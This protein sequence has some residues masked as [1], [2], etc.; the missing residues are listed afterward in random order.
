MTIDLSAVKEEIEQA[1]W[2]EFEP[3][4]FERRVYLGTVHALTPSGKF[5]TSF[6][7][8]NVSEAEAQGDM[9]FYERLDAE[10]EKFNLYIT[11][12]EHDPCDL[13]AYQVSEEEP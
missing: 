5:Y 11:H 9:E 13:F 3:G 12:G 8:G 1:P 4:M 2:E 7:C 6:A 10:A